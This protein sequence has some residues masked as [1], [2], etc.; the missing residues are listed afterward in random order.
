[1]TNRLTDERLREVR[2]R[3]E[4]RTAGEWID[5][6]SYEEEGEGVA[7]SVHEIA[8][9]YHGQHGY[10]RIYAPRA[11]GPQA[12]ARAD[13]QFIAAAPTDL[14]A[15]LAE[16]EA[17]RADVEMLRADRDA[18]MTSHY[19][20]L[21]RA[22]EYKRERDEERRRNVAAVKRLAREWCYE[23][24]EPRDDMPQAVHEATDILMG[25]EAING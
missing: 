13:A 2:A 18:Y 10:R 16:V 24:G 1:M 22:D 3:L 9:C 15:L 20:H 6:G 12:D 4:A 25:L 19:A 14:T 5:G 21:N 17:L 8:V 23:N 7:F 11:A